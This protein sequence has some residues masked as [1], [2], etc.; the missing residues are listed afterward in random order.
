MKKR[1]IF[2]ICISL[3]ALSIKSQH[4][5]QEL[6]QKEL[7]AL[8]NALVEDTLFAQIVTRFGDPVQLYMDYKLKVR[9][10]DS[11]WNADQKNLKCLDNIGYTEHF[12]MLPLI[13]WF[14]KDESL[15]GE[16]GVSYLIRTDESTILFD[17]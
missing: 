8:N 7:D 13:D 5:T 16:A 4:D 2:F 17:I 3:I 11:I 14:T 6:L 10:S 1:A 12:E 15:I 9:I